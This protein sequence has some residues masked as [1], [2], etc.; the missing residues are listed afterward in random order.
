MRL[1]DASAGRAPASSRDPEARTLYLKGR[2]FWNKRTGDGVQK[3]IDFF[4]QAV[5]RDPEYAQAFAGL[6]EAHVMSVW[7]AF[8]DPAQAIPRAKTAALAAV[9][10]QPKLAEAQAALG[11]VSMMEWN[12]DGAIR[13]LEQ[14]VALDPDYPRAHH[15][16]AYTMILLDRPERAVAAMRQ[17]Q[18]LDPLSLVVNGDLAEILDFAGHTDEAIDQA[19]KTIEMDPNFAIAHYSLERALRRKGLNAEA[20]QER[21]KGDELVALPPQE[22][23]DLRAAA[24]A[25]GWRAFYLKRKAQLTAAALA[26]RTQVLRA[27][28]HQLVA[29]QPGRGVRLVQP[30][31]RARRRED[32]QHRRRL[33][34]KHPR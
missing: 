33:R 22:I 30:R 10:L 32:H 11:S 8:T 13:A 26:G 4:E 6:A 24:A 34:R 3:A 29:R 31:I 5:S 15:L 12:W 9:R 14:A 19:R 16:Y 2:Y 1:A 27:W 28:T 23:A 25:G 17:A 20:L 7:Y 21:L 18:Q